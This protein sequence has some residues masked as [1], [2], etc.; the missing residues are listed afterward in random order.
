MARR[1]AGAGNVIKIES[2]QSKAFYIIWG[3][4]NCK[5]VGTGRDQ[6]Y[7]CTNSQSPVFTG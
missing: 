3:L 7:T 1:Q 4:L 5:K 2:L 6:G